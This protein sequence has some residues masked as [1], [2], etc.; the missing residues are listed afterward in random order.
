[1]NNIG[2]K[3]SP[4][5]SPLLWTKGLPRQPIS[6]ILDEDEAKIRETMF[7]HRCPNPI[8][9]KTI[10]RKPQFRE[11]KA[12]VISSFRNNNGD[13]FLCAFLITFFT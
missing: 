1:M 11:S 2:D 13:L 6:M 9:D 5:L 8:F 12:F 4:C 3:G 10:R 7:L